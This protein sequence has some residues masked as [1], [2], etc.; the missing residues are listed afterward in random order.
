MS[1]SGQ[2]HNGTDPRTP[3]MPGGDKAMPWLVIALSGGALSAILF[4]AAAAPSV[5]SLLMFFLAPLPLFM[6]GVAFGWLAAA[7]AAVVAAALLAGMLHPQ[8]AA[9]HFLGQGAPAAWL[10]WLGWQHR[11]FAGARE[12]EPVDASGNE[13]YPE[14]RLLL[15]MAAI[16]AS[17]VVVMLLTLGGLD[18]E[19]IRAALR[20]MISRMLELTGAKARLEPD[21]LK[22]AQDFF[23]AAGPVATT[24]IWLLSLYVSFR[25]ASWLVAR[26][27]LGG[28]PHADFQRLSFPRTAL[29]AVSGFSLAA[30]LPGIFGLLGE[31]YAVAFMTAFVILGLAVAHAYAADKPWRPWLMALIWLTLIAMTWLAAFPLLLLGLAEA[32]FGLRAQY[33]WGGAPPRPPAPRD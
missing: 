24:V 33:G 1:D 30:L 32:G 8:A 13:W 15:W 11:P 2:K 23:V 19:N 17:V 16:A 28:R 4:S 9:F 22:R 31:L 14:G 12:G 7:I 27:G 5:L 25:L 21:Q 6:V 29:L 3:G 26:F 20:Q 18:A 10:S